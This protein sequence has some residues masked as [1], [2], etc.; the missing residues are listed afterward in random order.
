MVGGEVATACGLAELGV[1]VA[2]QWSLTV[3]QRR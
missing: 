2:D 3:V 1:C